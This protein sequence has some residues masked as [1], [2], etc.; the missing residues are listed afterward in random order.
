MWGM[1]LGSVSWVCILG[2]EFGSV[3]NSWSLGLCLWL[4]FVILMFTS[5]V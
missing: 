1:D 2:M 5:Y 3:A 4:W